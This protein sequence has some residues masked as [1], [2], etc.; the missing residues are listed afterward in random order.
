MGLKG[1]PCVSVPGPGVTRA[2]SLGLERES[3]IRELAGLDFISCL[4]RETDWLIYRAP[5]LGQDGTD[6]TALHT[7][8]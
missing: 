2:G 6:K 7:A 5:K 3:P 1:C 8:Q 4:G